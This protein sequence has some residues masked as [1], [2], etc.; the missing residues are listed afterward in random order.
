MAPQY[1]LAG[2]IGGTTT[3]LLLAEREHGVVRTL[4][5][6][7]FDSRKYA[8]MAGVVAEFRRGEPDA[9]LD[10]ACFAVAGPV[11]RAAGGESVRVTNLPWEIASAGLA[12]AIGVPRLRLINDFEAVGYGIERL[13]EQEMV[14]LQEGQPE[15]H[16]TRAVL[17]AGTG[18]GQAILV[19]QGDRYAVLPT[20]GGHVDFGPADPLQV[21]LARW[22]IRQQGRASYEDFLSGGGL[23]RI[24]AFLRDRGLIPE[25]P[26]V[27][28]AVEQGDPAA[29]ISDAAL[30]QRDPLAQAAL[31][32]FVKIYG[33]QAGNLALAAGASGG[34]YVAGGIAPQILSRLRDGAFLAAFRSKGRMTKFMERIPLCVVIQ[35]DAGL[36]GA[37]ACAGRLLESESLA[38]NDQGC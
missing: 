22:L 13:G 16:G 19:W 32:L 27:A 2:D 36:R 23:A 30:K 33:A 3:R 18:L 5:E 11:R 34:V 12:R 17:G 21:E 4:A 10:A 1:L 20:E 31:D 28:A 29:A 8:G 35:P 24:Y 9:P 7:H 6:R 14:V 15:R 38:G 37:L 26:A 25:T